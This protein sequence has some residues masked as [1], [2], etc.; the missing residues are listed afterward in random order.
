MGDDPSIDAWLVWGIWQKANP[1]LA[2]AINVEEKYRIYRDVGAGL[3]NRGLGNPDAVS[4]IS[5]FRARSRHF[6]EMGLDHFSLANA[7]PQQ[8]LRPFQPSHGRCDPNLPLRCYGP[9]R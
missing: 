7:A 4:V 9:A 3:T 5:V 2:D 1:T 8:G 6:R